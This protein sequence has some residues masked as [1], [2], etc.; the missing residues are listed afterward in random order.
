MA[1]S[2]ETAAEITDDD[3]DAIVAE[4][5]GDEPEVTETP[6]PV[7][8]APA[9]DD[10]PKAGDETDRQGSGTGEEQDEVAAPEPKAADPAPAAAPAVPAGTPAPPAP[11][12][13]GKPFQ[14]RASGGV[15]TL[16]GAIELEDGSIVIPKDSQ[17]D[18]RARL[19]SERELAKNFKELRR[20]MSQKLT[21]A[22]RKQEAE[23]IESDAIAELFLQIQKMSPDERFEY[24]EKFDAE[25]PKLK[26]EIERKQL[27]REREALREERNPTPSPDEK[28]EAR[29]EALQTELRA[30]YNRVIAHPSVKALNPDDVNAVFRKHAARLERLV[31]K[32]ADGSEVFDDAEVLEDLEI[33]V[34]TAARIRASV[35]AG[36]APPATPAA[37]NAARNADLNAIPPVVAARPPAPAPRV[38]KKYKGD[39]S[40]FKNDFMSGAL[41]EDIE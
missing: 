1:E 11:T 26:L 32:E 17:A 33:L 27:E 37:R 31:Q 30:T 34:Q 6:E 23:K 38:V 35:P 21:A 10:A 29:Q 40:D 14:F 36:G 13:A 24:F 2:P 16:P 15:H 8:P 25:V 4:I 18:F 9:S 5:E 12:P 20:E 22:Q 28:A 39:R 3:L 41:D 19:A 7:S